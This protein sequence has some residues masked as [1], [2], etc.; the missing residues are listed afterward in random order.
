MKVRN[1]LSV[2]QEDEGRSREG[3]TL[4]LRAAERLGGS[5]GGT[6]ELVERCGR[7]PEAGIGE[8]LNGV[9]GEQRAA[10]GAD[11]CPRKKPREA[12][13]VGAFSSCVGCGALQMR[14]GSEGEVIH[15]GCRGRGV[16][17]L[18]GNRR[19]VGHGRHLGC[20]RSL[21]LNP[22][23]AHVVYQRPL[24]SRDSMFTETV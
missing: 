5:C 9:E 7:W 2:P 19:H 3:A 12:G 10:S 24:Y 16:G 4:F 1:P 13:F 11:R 18:F 8:M 20:L 21:G 6:S 17:G 22:P 15:F 14:C 23:G